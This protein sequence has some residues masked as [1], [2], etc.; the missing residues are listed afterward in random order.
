MAWKEEEHGDNPQPKSLG[1]E[2]AG[3]RL[4]T[5]LE[6]TQPPHLLSQHFH[7]FFPHE[8]LGVYSEYTD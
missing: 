3:A 2:A 4:K 7:E 5:H 6:T 8:H 1:H